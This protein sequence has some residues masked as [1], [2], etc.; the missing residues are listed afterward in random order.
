MIETKPK[1]RW[2]RFSLRTLFVLV[3]IVSVPLGWV[4]YQYKWISDRH[5]ALQWVVNG[6]CCAWVLSPSEIPWRLR[7][8]GESQSA[9]CIDVIEEL[10]K[11]DEKFRIQQLKDLFPETSIRL[12]RNG[13]IVLAESRLPT[14]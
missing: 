1:R 11:P 2:F 12:Y 10:V 6:Q 4:A 7:L 3:A 13:L 14:E 5:E 8:F 9:N